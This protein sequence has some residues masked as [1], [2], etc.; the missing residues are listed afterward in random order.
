[1]EVLV[2]EEV[3]RATLAL[4]EEGANARASG[5]LLTCETE[6]LSPESGADAK[7]VLVQGIQ[8]GPDGG[9]E[10]GLFAF[11]QQPYG[12][13]D[14]NAEALCRFAGFSVIHNEPQVPFVSERDGFGL[15]V[16]DDELQGGDHAF[17]CGF[18]L[19]QPRRALT[20]FRYD[21]RRRD[22]WLEQCRKQR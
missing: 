2:A 14:G 8:E 7:L 10:T 21:G 15:T 3:R 13:S 12:A 4:G 20:E 22:G 1:V 5:R 11:Q 18:L 6:R 17:V 9:N 19:D 16:V